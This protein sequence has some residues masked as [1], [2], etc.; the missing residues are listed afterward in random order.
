M[1]DVASHVAQGACTEVPPSAEV[2]G[3]IDL[4]VV[5]HGG[6]AN[7]GIPVQRVGHLLHLCGVLQTLR[8]DG[9]VGEGIHVGHFANLAVPD[10]LAHEVYALAARTLV[11]H[12]GGHVG[13]G[14]QLRQQA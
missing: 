4:I 8:P 6:R 10:P 5:A 9:T 7:P 1:Q 13:L 2:P 3:G 12:L 11:A 14:G